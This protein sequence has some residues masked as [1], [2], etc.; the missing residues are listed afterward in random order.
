M[1]A[2]RICWASDQRGISPLAKLLLIRLADVSGMDDAVDWRPFEAESYCGVKVDE[3]GV[4]L[5]DLVDAGLA[6]FEEGRLR[7]TFDR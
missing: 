6:A 7:L 4:A 5:G 2:E 3:I 1:S